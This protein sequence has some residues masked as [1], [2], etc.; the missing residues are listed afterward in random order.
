MCSH[1]RA[2]AGFACGVAGSETVRTDSESFRFF[3]SIVFR[4]IRRPILTLLL[5]T[6]YHVIVTKRETNELE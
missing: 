5:R 6:K 3:A 4:K 2:A 1:V